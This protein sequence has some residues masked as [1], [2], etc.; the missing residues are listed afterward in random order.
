MSDIAATPLELVSVVCNVCESDDAR[1]IGTGFDYEY[2]TSPEEFRAYRCRVCGCVY[3]SPRPDVSEFARIYPSTYHSLAF[4]QDNFAL[5]HKIRSRLETN[6]LLRYCEG[7]PSDARILDVGCGDGFHLQL[8]RTYGRDTWTVEG[9]DIDSRAV[10]RATKGGAT[11]HQGT[12]EE[13][14]LLQNQYDVVY[15]LQTV[16]HVA[17][18][19]SMLTAIHRVLKPGG[20][21]VIVTDNTGS[22]DFRWFQ[23]GL[24]GGYHF[25]RH[26]NL[27][28]RSSLTWLA[29]RAGYETERI[30]TIVSPVNWVYSI[31]N[32]LVAKQ[33][34]QWLVNRFT[35]KSPVSLGL[36]TVV[37]MVL[38][39]LGRGALLNAYFT[40]PKPGN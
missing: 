4:S 17:D 22:L 2:W 13:L 7:I 35:L 3:L 27:F 19:Y 29:T 32:Y 5:V 40:K 25:P 38:Q 20:R 39:K 33:A 16:E 11:V 18:P 15:T 26:W 34:P 6:R 10:E 36:F 9:I 37:D 1:L 30:D 21:L 24:W 12:I 31:H 28:D 14:E 23:K 8:L